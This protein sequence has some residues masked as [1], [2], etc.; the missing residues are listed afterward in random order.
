MKF[1]KTSSIINKND[2]SL[3]FN[4]YG[5]S[6]E[7]SEVKRYIG[8]LRGSGGGRALNW[9]A[10]L[11]RAWVRFLPS[12]ILFPS[13]FDDLNSLVSAHSEKKSICII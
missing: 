4:I 5:K 12:T 7:K 10:T 9:A 1:K 3:N 8:R 6:L 13:D 11:L 2:L